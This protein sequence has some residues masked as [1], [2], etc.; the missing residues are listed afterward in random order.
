V[1]ASAGGSGFALAPPDEQHERIGA[2]SRV[3]ASFARDRVPVHRVQWIA[4]SVPD[5]GGT[6]RRHFEERAV[7]EGRSWES[8]SYR[9]LLSDGCRGL[10]SHEVHVAI[11]LRS[12]RDTGAV[13][14]Q[15]P[16]R[17]VAEALAHQ[18]A[19]LERRL[20]EAG[21]QV[22]GVLSPAELAR[23]LARSLDADAPA[24]GPAGESWRPAV[25]EES[26]SAFRTGAAR[27]ATHWIAEWPRIDVAGDFLVPLLVRSAACRSVSLTM[28]PVPLARAIRDVERSRTSGAADA[29][30]RQRHGFGLTARTR[31]EQEGVLR[32]E[33]ELAD[34]HASFRISGYVTVS[35][36]EAAALEMAAAEA[37]HAAATAGLDLRR[38][39]GEQAVAFTYTL[40]C[41]RG[42]S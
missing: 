34:G 23:L 41:G 29:E 19:S 27:H 15:R 14:R 18:A 36:G 40:P 21:T 13:F 30:L 11:S 25:T 31:R 32:R 17:E 1:V 39:F 10:A 35:A 3:L 42:L 2:W 26:W 33:A 28:E 4:R 37:E 22:D 16:G 38:L 6:E 8:R 24:P 7:A 20:A 9:D 5:D 12:A